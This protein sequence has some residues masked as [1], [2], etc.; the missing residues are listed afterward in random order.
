MLIVFLGWCCSFC[1]SG[2]EMVLPGHRVM[3]VGQGT[4]TLICASSTHMFC[5]NI[6]HIQTAQNTWVGSGYDLPTHLL[7]SGNVCEVNQQSHADRSM[8]F[9]VLGMR[10]H[11]VKFSFFSILRS[12][13][14]TLS[15]CICKKKVVCHFNIFITKC[16]SCGDAGRICCRVGL[17]R[18]KDWIEIS[19]GGN[20][21]CCLFLTAS[22]STSWSVS[23]EVVLLNVAT[24]L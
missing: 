22:D 20:I 23:L 4:C 2:E 7:L 18:I 13:V 5:A 17:V 19:E 16:C 9:F 1:V 8:C 21:Y 12:K 15:S 24:L 3:V 11:T 10:K 6:W 14:T